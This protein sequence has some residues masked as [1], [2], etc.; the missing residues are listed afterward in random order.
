VGRGRDVDVIV[1]RVLDDI[2]QR[3]GSRRGPVPAKYA[4]LNADSWVAVRV[5]REVVPGATCLRRQLHVYDAA[6][7]DKRRVV[8]RRTHGALALFRDLL[9]HDDLAVKLLV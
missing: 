8:N 1:R 3:I 9:N 2:A 6:I 5:K 4:D 7:L